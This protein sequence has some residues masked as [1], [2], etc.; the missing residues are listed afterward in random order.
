[1]FEGSPLRFHA[2]DFAADAGNLFLNL[3]N[4]F[5]APGALL[6]NRAEA[7]FGFTIVFEASGQISVLLGDIFPG[8]RFTFDDSESPEVV[9]GGSEFGGRNTKGRLKIA[10]SAA[11]RVEAHLSEISVM[12]RKD[13]IERTARDNDVFH[14]QD[15]G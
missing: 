12:P 5:D 7:V 2:F 6:Q 15:E 3:K 11:L 14:L 9:D 1:M 13:A 10:G 4:I 8:L